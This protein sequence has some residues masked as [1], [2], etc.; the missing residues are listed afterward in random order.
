MGKVGK[1]KD[2][3]V[4]FCVMFALQILHA[5]VAQLNNAVCLFWH[6]KSLLFI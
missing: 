5:S 1:R 6:L 2:D 3:G 4:L